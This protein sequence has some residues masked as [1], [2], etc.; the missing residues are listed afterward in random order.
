MTLREGCERPRCRPARVTPHAPRGRS[1]PSCP[2]PIEARVSAIVSSPVAIWFYRQIRVQR[3]TRIAAITRSIMRARHGLVQG[4][5]RTLGPRVSAWLARARIGV[6]DRT[7]CRTARG[8]D[9]A[10]SGATACAYVMA[11][12]PRPPRM[13]PQTSVRATDPVDYLPASLLPQTVCPVS[14]G[15]GS[16]AI[17]IPRPNRRAAHAILP[18]SKWSSRIAC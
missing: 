8:L 6:C 17:L 13:T 7:R 1:H 4:S 15:T 3:W 12:V 2:L 9:D 14:S 18:R 16:P 5:S 10:A 11:T